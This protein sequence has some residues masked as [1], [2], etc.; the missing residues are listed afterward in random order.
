MAVVTA[1]SVGLSPQQLRE[2]LKAGRLREIFPGVYWSGPKQPLFRTRCQ[3]ALLWAGPDAVLSGTSA[4]IL[5]NLD[6]EWSTQVISLTLPPGQFGEHP[7]VKVHRT[8]LVP[9]DMTQVEG[10][11][12]TTVERTVVDLAAT[13]DEENLAIAF[14]SAWRRDPLFTETMR[15]WLP[16][17]EGARGTG[18]LQAALKDTDRRRRPLRS[19]L[20]VKLWRF[21]RE[22]RFPV[23]E[24]DYTVFDNQGAM[25]IDFAY[26]RRGLAL[27][28]DGYTAHGGRKEV[29]DHDAR[30]RS[31]LAALGYV[32]LSVTH[33]Q[34]KN[35]RAEL[36]LRLR[37]AFKRHPAS[38]ARPLYEEVVDPRV[39]PDE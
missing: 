9:A 26:P 20:E 30:R 25:V 38:R 12:C 21:L 1:S 8:Q 28:A 31:R 18:R 37:T 32:H 17:R 11:R 19:A 29:F 6:G 10:M 15:G 35:G 4:A 3:A 36:K 5:H 24:P 2:Q 23:P 33:D 13:T 16:L 34:L 22:H 7:E 27:E 14:E 39:D